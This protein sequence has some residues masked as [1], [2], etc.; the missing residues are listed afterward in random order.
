MLDY[1]LD[2]LFKNSLKLVTQLVGQ[3]I[4]IWNEIDIGDYKNN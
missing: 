3:Q 2:N 1:Y 4:I